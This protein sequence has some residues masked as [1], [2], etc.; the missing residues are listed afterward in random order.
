MTGYGRGEERGRLY[1]VTTEV[2][3][4]NNRFLEVSLRAPK[5]ISLRE[6]EIKDEVRRFLSRGKVNISI[7]LESQDDGAVPIKVNV[8]SARAYYQLL[9]EL[10]KALQLRESV[11]IDHLLHFSEIFDANSD[12]GLP[13]EEWEAVIRSL[14]EAL[15]ELHTMR[16]NEG[17][18]LEADMRKR[19]D[20]I[21][22]SINYVEKKSLERVPKERER[23]RERV[24][25]VLQSN[26]IDEQRIELELV[27]LSDKLD[28]TEE[29]VR[30]RSHLKYFKD[31]LESSEPSGRKLNFL[32]QEIHREV[33]TI[34]AK[35]SDAEISQM[36]VEVKEEIEKIREQ[37]QNIE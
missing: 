25:Q 20:K 16:K 34:G 12:N 33:N 32:I 10:R 2:R 35:A 4:V 30:L 24:R 6:Q 8:A 26:E 37:I 11:K 18:E 19:I 15:R 28:V 29:C 1:T 5:L 27:L 31:A 13:D 17:A 36:V 23:L 3:S 9:N 7:T 14:E 21:D 22:E